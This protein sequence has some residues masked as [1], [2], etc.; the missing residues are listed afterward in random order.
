MDKDQFHKLAGTRPD[1]RR[2][3]LEQKGAKV[4]LPIREVLAYIDRAFYNDGGGC[5]CGPV[6]YGGGSSTMETAL[7]CLDALDQ[8][9]F[10]PEY[11]KKL[12][13]YF[14]AMSGIEKTKRDARV[15]LDALYSEQ[16]TKDGR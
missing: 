5:G 3:L 6:F 4:N 7:S 2:R 16:M 12:R 10:S 11:T 15:A 13:A 8:Q 9:G 14:E 1:I